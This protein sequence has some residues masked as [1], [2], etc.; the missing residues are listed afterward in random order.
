M[1]HRA[2]IVDRWQKWRI[3]LYIVRKKCGYAVSGPVQL[4][5]HWNYPE[6]IE[7][8]NSYFNQL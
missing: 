3:K 1:L 7:N 2:V 6:I 5:I 4:Y 8:K